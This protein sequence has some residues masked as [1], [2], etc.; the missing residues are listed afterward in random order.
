MLDGE[1]TAT[2]F[3]EMRIDIEE[4]ITKLTCEL[5]TINAGIQN[6][7]EKVDIVTGLFSNLQ[8]AYQK[9]DIATKHHII[10]SIFPAKLIFEEKS[11]RTLEINKVVSLICFSDK[12][13]K[14]SKKRKHTSF[15]VLSRGV[16]PERFELSSKHR[17]NML[18]TCVSDI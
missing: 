3:K 9:R 1:I 18:S 16:E 12:A 4:K 13:F 6:L 2:E 10:S 17:I 11:V 15:G 5:S 8:T 7:G 14:E